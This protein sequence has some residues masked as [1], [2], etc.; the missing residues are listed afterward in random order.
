MQGRWHKFDLVRRIGAGGMAEIFLANVGLPGWPA[1]VVLKRV[2]PHLADKRDYVRMFADEAR[3]ASLLSHP[4]LLTHHETGT[5]QGT[6]YM[7]LEF[8]DGVNLSALMDETVR[9]GTTLPLPVAMHV[10][11]QACLGL[12]HAHDATD[13]NGRPLNLVHRDVSPQNVMLARSGAVKMLDF[14]IAKTTV[15]QTL[16]QTGL[17]K[18]KLGY[19]APEYCLGDDVD[20]RADVFSMGVTLYELV[21]GTRLFADSNQMRVLQRI[22]LQDV[23]APSR[24]RADVPHDLDRLVQDAT[25]RDRT[26]RIPDARMFALRLEEMLH[27]QGWYVSSAVVGQ[28]LV[29]HA[30]SLLP[31]GTMADVDPPSVMGTEL[32]S[33]SIETTAPSLLRT[34]P[35]RRPPTGPLHQDT[36]TPWSDVDMVTDPGAYEPPAE[37]AAQAEL[38]CPALQVAA[39]QSELNQMFAD[40]VNRI[41]DTPPNGSQ[42]PATFRTPSEDPFVPPALRGDPRARNRS[43]YARLFSPEG[44]GGRLR[45]GERRY[46]RYRD[47]DPVLARAGVEMSTGRWVPFLRVS[48]LEPVLGVVEPAG[49]RVV[50]PPSPAAD[51]RFAIIQDPQGGT[52]GL[53]MAA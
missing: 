35:L 27:Q 52:L 24:V 51:G 49:G 4:N 39:F 30:A 17:I 25:A 23:P 44:L 45:G 12:H 53:F 33:P 46:V 50:Q 14:G 20:R 47:T 29:E 19:M 9:R 34:M 16:T 13:E 18:G 22:T 1:Q 32:A 38:V 41:R 5:F 37:V 8:V 15:Q 40:S 3:V 31:G 10:V 48:A 43:F 42:V 21:T 28:W 11:A 2:L 36:A 7:A 6:P 26:R